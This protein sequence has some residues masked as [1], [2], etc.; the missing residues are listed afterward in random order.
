MEISTTRE[1]IIGLLTIGG[2][3]DIEKLFDLPDAR[4]QEVVILGSAGMRIV[5][6]GD[7]VCYT[8][9]CTGMNVSMKN[10]YNITVL[11]GQS[12]S[13]I[14]ISTDPIGYTGI[15]SPSVVMALSDEGVARRQKIFATL[16]PGSF[17][18]KEKSVDIPN[19]RAQVFEVDFKPFK[20]TRQDWALA[21]LA[22]LAKKNQAMTKQMLAFAITS[23]FNEKVAQIAFQTIDK[24]YQAD[25]I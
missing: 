6:A 21:S 20:I 13:E 23:R 2:T 7:I 10:D 9:L 11:R 8:G 5:T 22:I 19:T 18:V 25:T 24:I 16:I 17:I 4:R 14:L 12:V 15:D 1:L 3:P